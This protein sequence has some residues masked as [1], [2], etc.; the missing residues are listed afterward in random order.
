MIVKRGCRRCARPDYMQKEALAAWRT[1]GEP[2]MTGLSENRSLGTINR[3]ELY[4]RIAVEMAIGAG[5]GL[6]PQDLHRASLWC[7]HRH[8]ASGTGQPAHG[9]RKQ[10]P[11]NTVM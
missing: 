1:T 9:G 8:A 4:E 11:T 3:E 6:L 5:C 7:G 10:V 2:G